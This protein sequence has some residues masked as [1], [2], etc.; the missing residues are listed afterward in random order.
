MQLGRRIA[1]EPG[2]ALVIDYGHAESATGET[3][4]AVREHLFADPLSTPGEADMTAHVDFQA[5]GRAVESMGANVFGPIEQSLFLDRLGIGTRAQTLKANAS[6][7]KAHEIDSAMARLTGSGRT[8][9]G[10]LFKA[11]AVAH[12]SL[13]TPA[14]FAV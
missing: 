5:L 2:A 12:R 9:M 8:G 7:T 4:Q 1:R 11:M 6:R 3:L 13:G 10:T 14:G